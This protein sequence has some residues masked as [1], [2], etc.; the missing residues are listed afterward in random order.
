MS[1]E[2][3]VSAL[4]R[5]GLGWGQGVEEKAKTATGFCIS[6]GIHQVHLPQL[7]ILNRFGRTD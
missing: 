1:D 4:G 3:L 6:N 5:G 2:F 7:V